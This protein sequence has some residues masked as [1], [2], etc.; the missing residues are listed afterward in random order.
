M[1]SGTQSDGPLQARPLL[2]LDFL[3]F[4]FKQLYGCLF[5]SEIGNC[6]NFE[7]AFFPINLMIVNRLH[8]MLFQFAE[9]RESAFIEHIQTNFP[10]KHFTIETFIQS[11]SFQYEGCSIY[12]STLQFIVFCSDELS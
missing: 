8:E 4:D 7:L 1:S 5:I 3:H 9:V 6:N 10:F 12:N 2:Y 11:T